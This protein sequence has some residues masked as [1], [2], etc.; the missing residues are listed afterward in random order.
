MMRRLKVVWLCKIQAFKRLSRF[1]LKYKL[2]QSELQYQT[3]SKKLVKKTQIRM[4]IS[5][6]E[7]KQTKTE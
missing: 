6:N 1:P 4:K 5:P 2:S 7:K 3:K